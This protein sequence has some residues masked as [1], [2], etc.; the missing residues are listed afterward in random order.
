MLSILIKNKQILD[1][2]YK[3]TF[4]PCCFCLSVI[5]PKLFPVNFLNKR[6]DY[7]CYFL[8]I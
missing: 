5:F 2:V 1:A 7:D 6:E 4:L 3:K 8:W